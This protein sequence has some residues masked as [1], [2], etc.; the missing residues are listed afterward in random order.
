MR[1]ADMREIVALID[2]VLQHPQD[3]QAQADV[4]VQAKTLCNRF[5]I[6]HAYDSSPT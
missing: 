2:R 4:R 5:P 1:E 6:F 3:Q